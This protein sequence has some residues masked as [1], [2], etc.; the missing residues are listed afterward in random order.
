MCEGYRALQRVHAPQSN[1]DDYLKNVSGRNSVREKNVYPVWVFLFFLSKLRQQVTA[2]QVCSAVIRFANVQMQP[3][4]P[5]AQ[6][7]RK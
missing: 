5:F 6:V 4:I 3:R 1:V 7:V 2:L